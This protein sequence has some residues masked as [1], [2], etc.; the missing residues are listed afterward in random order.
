MLRII[1]EKN[2]MIEDAAFH[3][4]DKGFYTDM[5]FAFEVLSKH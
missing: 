4:F 2:L 1:D 3:N 5:Q